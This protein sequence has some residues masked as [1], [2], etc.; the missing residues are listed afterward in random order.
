LSPG[1]TLIL[2]IVLCVVLVTAAYTDGTRGKIYNW[3]TFPAILA[4]LILNFIF[5]YDVGP[6]EGLKWSGLGLAMG[7]A[8]LFVPFALGGTKAGDVKLL[9]AVISRNKTKRNLSLRP[10]VT[11]GVA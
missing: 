10:A 9:A 7:L 1:E 2:N 4:G 8:L 3:L 11:S 6:L 5:W